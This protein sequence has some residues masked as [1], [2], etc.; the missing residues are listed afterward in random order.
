[1]NTRS[2][3]STCLFDSIAA[4]DGLVVVEV[5]VV[6]D[7]VDVAQ[8][9]ELAQLERRELHLHRAA[10]A[11]DVHIRHRRRLQDL[12]DVV[13]DLSRQQVIG[14]LR[15]HAGDVER[16]V[17]V[18]DDGDLLRVERPLARDI[19]M[20]VV[21]A[22][23]I[24]GAVAARQVDAGDVEVGIPD[25]TGREDDGVV[26]ALEVVERDVAPV[27]HVAEQPDA[28]GVEHLAQ[29]GDDA[30]DAWM[31][32]RDAVA[33]EPVGRREL[34]EQVDRDLEGRLGLQQDVGGV[35]ARR[36]C[37]DDG[38]PELRHCLRLLVLVCC[39]CVRGAVMRAS[40][41][42]GVYATAPRGRLLPP[43]GSH[44]SQLE[45]STIVSANR[46]R[47]FL[48]GP[49]GRGASAATASPAQR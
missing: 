18:A 5:L 28:T 37:A 3:T 42:S 26:V 16:D 49:S 40:S 12:V 33:N 24:G 32:G 6:H 13:G 15:E 47:A 25:R 4:R 27:Q 19:R 35:D 1:M 46:V 22:H 9:A 14:V 34:L 8:F 39:S 21:P 43:R 38:Q 20:A 30:L 2:I 29:G 36:P 23:E 44:R 11:E 48:T 10:A 45:R 31:I 41:R 17:A 7:H